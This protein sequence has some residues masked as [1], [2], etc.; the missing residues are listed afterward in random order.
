MGVVRVAQVTRGLVVQDAE[1]MDAALEI[2]DHLA[3]VA[4]DGVVVQETREALDPLDV[5]DMVVV[6]Q[7][8]Q[9]L[10]DLVDQD[11][12]DMDAILETLDHLALAV[13]DGVVVQETL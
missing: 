11:V 12:E 1:D 7:A 13:E 3:L 5:E 4:E 2:L 6:R 9:E 10:V 8:R